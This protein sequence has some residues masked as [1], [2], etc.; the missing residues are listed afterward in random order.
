MEIEEIA[1]VFKIISN[2]LRI[3]IMLLLAK[4]PKKP[5]EIFRLLN[6]RA[7]L[8]SAYLTRLRTAGLIVKKDGAYSLTSKGHEI[9]DIIFELIRR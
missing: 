3:R 4:G 8:L 9:M 5:N 7:P 2:P 6:R 1:E